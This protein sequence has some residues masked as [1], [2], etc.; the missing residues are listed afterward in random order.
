VSRIS[1]LYAFKHAPASPPLAS[2]SACQ[3]LSLLVGECAICSFAVGSSIVCRNHPESA[4]LDYACGTAKRLF[5]SRRIAKWGLIS[6][7][8]KVGDRPRHKPR[9]T[10]RGIQSGGILLV[11]GSS[12]TVVDRRISCRISHLY[13]TPQH[14]VSTNRLAEADSTPR[15]SLRRRSMQ[16]T[17]NHLPGIS[18]PGTWVKKGRS[19]IIDPD[20]SPK[21]L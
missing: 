19:P 7:V 16:H 9:A 12:L 17:A 13:P 20:P 14:L 10:H 11:V 8:A 2:I 1:R 6:A 18:L 15:W 3:L 5:L 4:A 21:A